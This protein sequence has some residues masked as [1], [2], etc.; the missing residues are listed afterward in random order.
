MLVVCA[1]RGGLYANLTRMI[2][3]E[4]PDVETGRRQRACDHPPADEGGAT[5]PGRTLVNALAD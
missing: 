3:F 5:R 2:D 1:E 4:V